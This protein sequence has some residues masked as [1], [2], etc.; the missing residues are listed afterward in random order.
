MLLRD[1]AHV[2]RRLAGI[3]GRCRVRIYA[4]TVASGGL[5]VV[6]LT[7]LPSNTG[8]S[9]TNEVEQIAAEVLSRYL[10]EQDGAEPPF[11]LV[12]HYP[13]TGCRR[14]ELAAEHF[15]LVTFAHYAGRPRWS[16]QQRAMAQ[17]F[18]EPDWRRV[19]RA[20]VE[21]WIGEALPEPACTCTAVHG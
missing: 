2:Y 18:G 10:P 17:R 3:E 8:P 15:D 20:Q 13:D 16:I 12:E 14:D 21:Q 9:V 4:P 7:E 6:L 5:P 1:T 11:A 19:D